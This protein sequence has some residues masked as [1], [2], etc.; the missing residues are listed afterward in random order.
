MLILSVILLM[1]RLSQG[2]NQAEAEVILAEEQ[3]AFIRQAGV[4]EEIEA[5]FG[6]HEREG[7]LVLTDRRLMFICTNEE[8][9]DLPFSMVPTL[10]VRLLFSD[11]ED[12]D[13]VPLRPPN[14]FIQ[15]GS[16]SGAR[17][18]RGEL[19]RPSLE[20]EWQDGDR[21]RAA[22][23]TETLTGRRRRNLNDW[24]PIIQNLKAGNQKLVNVPR[25]PS[26]DSLDGK[27]VHV[28]SDMQE[29]GVFMI[30]EA[31]EKEFTLDLDPDE[32]Q[33]ACDRLSAQGIL[34]RLP[35]SSGDV[36]YRRASPLGEDD[37]SS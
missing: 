5:E 35:D 3:G 4:K 27:I 15:L 24:A 1:E 10:G 18:H 14:L 11:V 20:I 25:P 31:V 26:P 16:I 21:R 30:E 12:L 37:F 28:L 13:Q 19:G 17:G 36:F 33:A 23:F 7:T 2:S 6:V 29:K 9:E 8:E 32:V 22:V 34:V